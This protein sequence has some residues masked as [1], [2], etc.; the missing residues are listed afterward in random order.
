MT[1]RTG[2]RGGLWSPIVPDM[3]IDININESIFINK[4]DYYIPFVIKICYSLND[5]IGLNVFDIGLVYSLL[6]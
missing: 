6:A 5:I 1:P 4:I 3:A 2:C